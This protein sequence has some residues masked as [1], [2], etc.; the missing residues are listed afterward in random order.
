MT[1]FSPT[2]NSSPGTHFL[3]NR[4]T[5][6]SLW[7]HRY[8]LV[9][10]AWRK[11]AQS[12]LF[13]EVTLRD[14]LA[15]KSLLSLFKTRK[16]EHVQWLARCVRVLNFW[17][18]RTEQSS[19]GTWECRLPVAMNWFPLLYELRLGVDV[20]QRLSEST[21]TSLNST[22]PIRALQI[23]MRSDERGV[24][25]TQSVLPFQVLTVEAWNLKFVVMRGDSFNLAGHVAFPPV[26]HELVEFRWTVPTPVTDTLTAE[27]ITY[28]TANSL[29]TLQVLHIPT[30]SHPVVAKVA[31]TLR[32]LKVNSGVGIPK[33][34]NHLKELIIADHSFHYLDAWLYSTLPLNITHLGILSNT[35]ASKNQLEAFKHNF[36]TRLEVFSLYYSAQGSGDTLKSGMET[37]MLSSGVRVRI[38]KGRELAQVGMRSDLVQS[39]VYPRGVSVGNMRAMGRLGSSEVQHHPTLAPNLLSG[40]KIPFVSK[41][42]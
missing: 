13:H 10:R 42:A 36:P 27:L 33:R 24:M 2:S 7:A 5:D 20:M 3:F 34:L 30:G 14:D 12:L 35:Y 29:K 1:C 32:S 25:A 21:M 18:T 11:P 15:Y 38:F 9:A 8:A 31:P 17:I 16:S 39:S 28:V 4:D 6:N 26:R 40:L 23:A 19:P 22:P 41:S 37:Y